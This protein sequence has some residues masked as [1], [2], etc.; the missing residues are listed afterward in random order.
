MKLGDTMNDAAR[1]FGKPLD[2]VRILAVEQMQS[3][4]YATQLLARLG[5]DVVKV[6]PPNGGDSGRGALPAIDDPQGRPMGATFLRNNLGKRSISVNLKDPRGRDLVLRLASRFDV[7]CQNFRAGVIDHLGLGYDAVAAIHPRVVYCSISGFGTR[8]PTPYGDR[9]AYAPI[10]EAMAGLYDFRR[11]PDRAPLASPLGALGD[12]G[13]ALFATIGILAALRHRD[14][15]G[16]GEHVD[17]AM[18]DAMI[19]LGDAGI[20]YLSLGIESGGDT[21][22]INDAFAASDG[23]FVMQ[24]GRRHMF[25]ALATLIGTP[26]WLDDPDLATGV[27]WRA[28]LEDRIRPAVEAWAAP[29][30]RAQACAAL[31]DVGIAAG[32]V[33]TAAEVI[34]DEH[35]AL[36]GMVVEIERPNGDGPP[37]LAVGNPVKLSNTT[38]GPETRMPWLGEHTDTVLRAELDLDD[39]TI[40]TLHADGV[41]A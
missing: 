29:R 10:V 21:P 17:I 39:D 13:A 3:L 18:L 41:I 11:Y 16:M 5:A 1:E 34:A 38:E 26:E 4:P 2:G 40:A 30:T 20:N 33:R 15:T 14:L 12:T 6:E 23:Y 32:P 8:L 7:F 37:V 35:T 36:H 27:H 31:G 19:A 28:R 25:E 22:G 24:C 9:P